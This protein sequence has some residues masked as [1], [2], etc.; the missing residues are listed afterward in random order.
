M[1]YKD[2][3]KLTPNITADEGAKYTVTWSSSDN[4]IARVDENGNVYAAKKGTATITCTV[5]D[6]NGNTATDTS[7]VTVK[8][9]FVQILIRIFLLGF[10]WY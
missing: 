1:N 9:T 5:T 8:Y 2:S 7:K 4:K 6:S 10:L 3:T